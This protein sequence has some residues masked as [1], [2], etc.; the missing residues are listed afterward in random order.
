MRP[1]RAK[2]IIKEIKSLKR[3][4][5]KKKTSEVFWHS[6]SSMIDSAD[7]LMENASLGSNA[8]SLAQSIRGGNDEITGELYLPF[9]CLC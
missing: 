3:K 7:E 5:P 2:K 4:Q 8:S 9:V 1:Y 6:S